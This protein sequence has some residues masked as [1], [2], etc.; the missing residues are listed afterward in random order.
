MKTYLDGDF[1]NLAVGLRK[2]TEL[3]G[4]PDVDEKISTDVYSEIEVC[5]STGKGIRLCAPAIPY[6]IC[7]R[8]IGGL[9][10]IWLELTNRCNLNCIHCYNN[11]GH[12]RQSPPD[13]SYEA[14]RKV[15]EKSYRKGCKSA[16]FT[17]G[18]P[19]MYAYLPQLLSYARAVGYEFIE[20]F[21][22]GTLLTDS[23]L[24]VV[25]DVRANLAF[26][27]YASRSDVHDEITR[28]EGS[29][30]KTK[31]GIISARECGIPMRAGVIVMRHNYQ[32]IGNT[33]H[34]LNKLGVEMITI[35]GVRSVGRGSSVSMHK[36]HTDDGCG[37]CGKDTL[38]IDPSGQLFS[39]IFARTN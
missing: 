26:S 34:F 27:V 35:D 5:H 25:K 21:T 13:M 3:I 1:K 11:S 7:D 31:E 36:H 18:E 37:V 38:C 2:E 9:N 33:V 20:I 23:L 8:R 29:F 32:E 39:C 28:T 19:T 12:S 22:N 17:G 16:Q 14:W 6:E 24:R 15:L 30:L 4:Q 10:F